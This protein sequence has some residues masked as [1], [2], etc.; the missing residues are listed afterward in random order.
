MTSN[1]MS[2]IIEI[3]SEY[4][5]VMKVLCRNPNV[6]D[7]EYLFVG[8]RNEEFFVTFSDEDIYSNFYELIESSF[9]FGRRLIGAV[10]PDTF[11]YGNVNKLAF[12]SALILW[13]YVVPVIIPSSS[14]T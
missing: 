3:Y 5:V 8:P 11:Q 4:E 10:I 14:S 6:I 13:D 12:Y 7:K 9:G 1:L 2:Y